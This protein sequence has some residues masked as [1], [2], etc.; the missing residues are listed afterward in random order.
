MSNCLAGTHAWTEAERARNRVL[1]AALVHDEGQVE[2]LLRV[3]R[4][5]SALLKKDALPPGVAETIHLAVH[6][7][8]FQWIFG[9]GSV[10]ER[11]LGLIRAALERLIGSVAEVKLST[12]GAGDR[13]GNK[14]KSTTPRARERGVR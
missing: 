10:S 12:S 4:D 13:V 2:P 11:R 3:D 8:W 9:M 6:G 5:V 7:L 14:R 1:V